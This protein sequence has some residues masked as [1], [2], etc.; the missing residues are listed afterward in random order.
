MRALAGLIAVLLLSLPVSSVLAQAA[1]K[2]FQCWI[3]ENGQRAC[4]DRVPPQYAQQERK[5]YEGG[6]VVEIKERPRTPEELA[7][8]ERQKKA[9]VE[10][11]RKE[12]EQRAYDQFLLSTFNNVKDLERMRDQRIA[13]LDSRINLAQKA[14]ADNEQTLKKLRDQAAKAEGAKKKVPDRVQ[15]QI[16]EFEKSLA[17]NRKGVEQMQA[18]RTQIE[19]KFTADIERLKVLRQSAGLPP[20]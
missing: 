13:T 10:A 14:L 19:T 4:G 3:E 16:K 18:E 7:E 15:K 6:R 12:E 8:I 20:S 11:K 2:R 9:A 17:D 1:G 5:V